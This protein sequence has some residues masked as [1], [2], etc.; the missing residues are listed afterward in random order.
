MAF[1]STTEWEVRT[2][3]SNNNGGGFADLD[4]GT[5]VDYSQQDAAQFNPT[6]LA[7]D[8][9]GTGLS[10]A[11]GGFTAA[12]VG[13][14]LDISGGTLTA[15]RYQ[16]TA[17]TDTNNVTIDRSAGASKSGGTGYVGGAVADLQEIDA[18]VYEG[19]TVWVKAGTYNTA[20]AISFV[21]YGAVGDMIKILGYNATHGDTP[22]GTDRPLLQM[23]GYQIT[24]KGFY[25]FEN[26]RWEGTVQGI[27][28]KRQNLIRNCKFTHEGTSGT[29]YCISISYSHGLV[30]EDCEFTSSGAGATVYGIMSGND[31]DATTVLHSYFHDMDRGITQGTSPVG[32]KV[33]GC[34]FDNLSQYGIYCQSN[35]PLILSNTFYDCNVGLYIIAGKLDVIVMNNQFTDGVNGIEFAATHENNLIDYNNYYNNSGSDVTNCSK[36]DNATANDPGYATPGSDFSD[37][38]DADG[39]TNRLFA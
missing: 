29:K 10:S 1:D 15:G 7:T 33:V 30:V 2:T 17:Y 24:I 38:D 37:V 12:M 25:S 3:G 5:S 34:I 20:A 32:L 26:F 6:D 19:N 22:T 18:I 16:I 27:T 36:G 14:V 13:N 23:A 31:Q 28:G 11:T 8:G 35:F 21:D 9:A 4:P 39:F